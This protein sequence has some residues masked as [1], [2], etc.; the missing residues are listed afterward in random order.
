MKYY[1]FKVIS[2]INWNNN[3]DNDVYPLLIPY[4]SEYM[5]ENAKLVHHVGPLSHHYAKVAVIKTFYGNKLNDFISF[6]LIGS[7]VGTLKNYLAQTYFPNEK[8]PLACVELCLWAFMYVEK[9]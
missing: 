3:Y 4:D 6:A 8:Y 7:K 5:Y 2:S 1:Y 9:D